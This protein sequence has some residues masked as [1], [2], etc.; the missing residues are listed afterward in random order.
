MAKAGN[1]SVRAHRTT[2]E[3]VS[4][5]IWERGAL[6]SKQSN[7]AIH[8]ETINLPLTGRDAL[9]D[10][11]PGELSVFKAPRQPE[12]LP[13]ECNAGTARASGDSI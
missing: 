2:S 5:S 8:K 7:Q 12:M 9:T 11:Q 1:F 10:M 4:Y 6:G 13:G 3:Q